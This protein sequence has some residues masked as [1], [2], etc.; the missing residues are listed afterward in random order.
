M[1]TVLT[2]CLPVIY[3]GRHADKYMDAYEVAR[4]IVVKLNPN[5]DRVSVWRSSGKA[6]SDCG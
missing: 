6:P 5:T 4:R 2:L 3:P 1:Y